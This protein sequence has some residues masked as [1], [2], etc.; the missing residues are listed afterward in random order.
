MNKE[1]FLDDALLGKFI[2]GE[3][4]PEE[5]MLINDWI[6]ASEENKIYFSHLER[7]WALGANK[8]KPSPKK[9]TVWTALQLTINKKE[10]P[11]KKLFFTPYRI[12]AAILLLVSVSS[13]LYFLKSSKLNPTEIVWET[14]QTKNEVAQLNLPDGSSVIVNRNSNIKWPNK[15]NGANREILLEGEAFFDVIHDPQRPF[16]ITADE[17]KIKVLGTAFN[18]QHNS[19]KDEIETEVTRGKVL[20]YSAQQQIIIEAGMKG[21]YHQ[22]T[23]EL[24][25]VKTENKNSIAYATH[26]LSFSGSTLKEITDQLSKAYGVQFN[27]ENK[28]IQ[29]CRLTSEYKDKS[30]SFI[31]DV[32]SESLNLTYTVKNNTVYISGDGCL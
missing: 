22:Q 25:L 6:A 4:T 13:L 23:K 7:T 11:A 10:K 16:V 2:A 18:V 3:A 14:K 19:G 30:L 12:A 32:I 29:D 1:N 31:M 28:K 20:M 26:S 17:I 24:E 8:I 9:E 15:L 27:F 21:I 5:A